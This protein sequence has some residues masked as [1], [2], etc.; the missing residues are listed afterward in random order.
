MAV[1][2]NV[3]I[4]GGKQAINSLR[5]IDPAL[6]KQF[7]ADVNQV[8]APAI[9]AGANAYTVTPLSNMGFGWTD[10][11]R[12]VFP[13][14]VNKARAGVR[15]R[16]DTRRKATAFILIEQ[17]NPAAAI[18]ETAGR[19][20]TNRLGQ[21]LDFVAGERGFKRAEAGRTRLYGR[22]VYKARKDIEGEMGRVILKV[23]NDVQKELS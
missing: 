16:I 21:S 7:K 20:T 23:V 3:S 13:F 11:G 9:R 18:F 1:D 4:V 8:A 19:K 22:A 2:T 14:D 17:I 5:K 15:A 12:R 10:R 6:Q